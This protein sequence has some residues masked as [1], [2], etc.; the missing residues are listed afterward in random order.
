VIRTVEMPYG[1]SRRLDQNR[2][3]ETRPIAR[4]QCIGETLQGITGDAK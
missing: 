4:P 2:E 3:L 1:L